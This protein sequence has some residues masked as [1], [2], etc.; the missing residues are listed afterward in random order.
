MKKKLFIIFL[1]LTLLVTIKYFISDY[2]IVY[3]LDNHKV[4]TTYK[5]SRFYISIDDKFNFDIYKK[6]GISKLKIKK[7]KVI[8]SDNLI[9]L[10]PEIKNINTYPLCYYN[11]EYVDYKLINNEVL[12]EYKT[13]QEF[14]S[15]GN[16][17]FNNSL[18][19]KEYVYLWNYK[20]FYQMN[21][22]K[23]E[24]LD[25]F[26]EGKYDNSLMYKID[27]KI[28]FPNYDQEYE[29]NELYVL[30]MLNGK[31]NK[32]E[33]KY[34]IS[35]NSYIVGNIGRILY[36]F[37]IKESYLY[38]IDTKRLTIRL[39][40]SEEL[41]YFKYEGDKKVDVNVTEYKNRN[42]KYNNEIESNYKYEIVDNKLYKSYIEDDLKL[43]IFEGNSIKIIGE[44]KDILYFV[45][46]DKFYKY[47]PKELVKVF[48]YFELNF[49]EN[50]I[51][52]TY[53]K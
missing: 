20:G 52:Y 18:T 19:K 16:F 30:D 46:E 9:C 43:K 6:R 33:S 35:Y 36:L 23:L 39:V 47:T 17:Y 49:N 29:F 41:G 42:I 2:K 48:N 24:T 8:E 7:I 31:M 13:I 50:N 22:D 27:D 3:I 25:L 53:N 34:D 40:G 28:I 44:Y 32:I 37:D 45:S 11:E 51:I 1:I 14:E 26:K 4:E 38:E 21:N 5:D 10:Y 15:D 12:N